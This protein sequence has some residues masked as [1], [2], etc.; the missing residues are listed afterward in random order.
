MTSGPT[1]AL[2][3]DN[4]LAI[5]FYADSGFGRTLAADPSYTE[6]VNVSP[7]S[8]MEFVAEDALPLRGDT[9]AARVS[10]GAK[11]AVADG[12]RGVQER[13][14]RAASAPRAVD[15][16]GLAGVLGRR[17]AARTRQRRR[18]RLEHRRRDD[19]LDGVGQRVVAERVAGERDELRHDDG[20]SVD[21]GPRGGD[22]HDRRRRHGARRR[23]LAADDPGHADASIRPT[24]PALSVSPAALSFSAVAGG[25]SPAAKT[26]A[27]SNTGGGSLNWTA[28]EN[29]SWLAVSPSSGTNAG[30][31]TV[32][33]STSGLAAGTYTEDITLAATGAT[34]SPKTVTVT[35]TLDP[36]TPP[37]LSVSPGSLSFSAAAGGSNP[38]P[39]TLSIS[40]TGGGSLDWTASESAS[41]LSVSP[42]S[43][44][45]A[46][47]VTVTPS[48]SGLAAGTY[49]EDITVAAAGATGSPKTV[50]VTLT[51][52]P[53]PPP[54]LSLTPSSS[55]SAATV[56]GG[57]PSAR[58]GERVT[59]RAP[60]R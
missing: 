35:L 53:P 18:C 41:W 10:T 38:A 1:A 13:R 22:L 20:D 9:P 8:D 47:T 25:P 43:G 32:T 46:G 58:D 11:H 27:V 44:T 55:R 33:P 34:G 6:R 16:A 51:V 56:G 36:P 50:T 19:G 4:G 28:S 42:G 21:L 15:R 31:M 7:T 37:A 45:N 5:G 2:T 49:T 26:I 52:D 48:I 3:G 23:G 24:P 29:A 57:D 59:I 40:N 30:T 60:A 54:V 39:K 14:R 12:D 17:P